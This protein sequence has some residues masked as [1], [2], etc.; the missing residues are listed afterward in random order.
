MRIKLH[1]GQ[2][3]ELLQKYDESGKKNI[4]TIITSKLSEKQNI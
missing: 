3:Y 4:I 1:N 2:K